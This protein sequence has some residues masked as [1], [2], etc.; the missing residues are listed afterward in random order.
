MEIASVRFRQSGGFAGLIRG[1]EISG[2]QITAADR[3]ALARYLKARA[4]APARS[5]ARD[6]LVYE[7][8]VEAD[9]GTVRLEFDEVGA[10]PELSS[11]IERLTACTRPMPL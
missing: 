7:I 10:P 8:E 3:R 6:L 2:D 4:A 5:E 1:C 9:S 11:F